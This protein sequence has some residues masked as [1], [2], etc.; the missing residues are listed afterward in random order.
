MHSSE[1][2]IVTQGELADRQMIKASMLDFF[3]D[4]TLDMGPWK[5]RQSLPTLLCK[6]AIVQT[7]NTA[8]LGTVCRQAGE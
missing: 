1:H 6:E 4:I 8:G 5:M 2:P 3:C 7:Y